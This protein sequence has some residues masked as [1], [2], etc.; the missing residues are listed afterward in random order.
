M[1]NLTIGT[2]VKSIAGHDK[3]NLF[4]IINVENEYVYL[5]DGKCRTLS[6]PKKKKIKHVQH[7]ENSEGF[8]QLRQ[9]FD[10]L[11]DAHIRKLIRRTMLM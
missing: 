1:E 6:K 7:V 10:T 9:K 5:V 8:E 11:L 4:V 2:I 3:D